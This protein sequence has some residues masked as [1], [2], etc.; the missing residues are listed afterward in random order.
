MRIFVFV[1]A[2]FLSAQTF[3]QGIGLPTVDFCV[4]CETIYDYTQY[5]TC[6]SCAST[7]EPEPEPEPEPLTDWAQLLFY[8]RVLLLSNCALT[9]LFMFYCVFSFLHKKE[10]FG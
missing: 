9:G 3:A 7:P 5:E 10:F 2:L 4:K 8:M 6:P 1:I